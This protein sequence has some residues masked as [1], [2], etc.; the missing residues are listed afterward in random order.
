MA[1]VGSCVSAKAAVSPFVYRST[2]V[3]AAAMGAPGRLRIHSSS[4]VSGADVCRD[5]GCAASSSGRGVVNGGLGVLGGEPRVRQRDV[6]ATC[7]ASFEGVRPV[8]AAS[9]AAAVASA[10]QPA[11]AS[12]AFPER[13]KVVA[14]VAAIMLLCNAHRVVMSVA[15]VPMAAQY[16]WSS[17]FVGIVQ[18]GAAESPTTSLRLRSPYLF[19]R[20]LTK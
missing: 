19:V 20:A 16:G 6:V 1:P 9:A 15:V 14:L 2:R 11:A 8:P 18:V 3:G 4:V 5:G 7:S 17:S 13:A 12:S 10:V